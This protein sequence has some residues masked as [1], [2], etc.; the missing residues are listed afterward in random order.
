MYFLYTA[1]HPNSN[2]YLSAPRSGLSPATHNRCY[3]NTTIRLHLTNISLFD[4]CS[5]VMHLEGQPFDSDATH[6]D[7]HL[8]VSNQSCTTIHL[9]GGKAG[10]QETYL[11]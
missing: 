1:I 6:F 2:R 4:F 10:T 11:I 9:Y 5:G 8:N 7:H 3:L